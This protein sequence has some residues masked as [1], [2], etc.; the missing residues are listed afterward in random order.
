MQCELLLNKMQLH[1]DIARGY[2]KENKDKISEFWTTTANDLN[3]AGPPIKSKTEWK[4][5]WNDQKRYVRKK[6]TEN[7]ANQRATG[8]G[9]NK[10]V[11]YTDVE[12]AILQLIGVNEAVEGFGSPFG[13]PPPEKKRKTDVAEEN[14]DDQNSLEDLME[15]LHEGDDTCDNIQDGVPCGTETNDVRNASTNLEPSTSKP[16]QP[17]NYKTARLTTNDLIYEE[18]KVQKEISSNI[19]EVVGVLKEHNTD[20][21]NGFKKIYRSLDRICDFSK[22]RLKEEKRHH[23]VIEAFRKQ[24]LERRT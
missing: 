13:L 23:E 14:G 11:K 4:K 18:L 22:Q 5:V 9:P 2:S 21:Q 20:T 15:Y 10:T 12:E 16:T 7:K 3:S 1:P 19:L 24:E 17:R 6:A 8:G